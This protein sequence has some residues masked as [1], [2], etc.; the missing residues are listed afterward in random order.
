MKEFFKR[1][2]KVLRIS[3][4]I[5][6]IFAVGGAIF[7]FIAIGD[8]YGMISKTIY[9]MKANGTISYNATAANLDT[10]DL[11]LHNV[12]ANFIIIAGGLLF[13]VISVLV[14]IF[15][16]VSIGAPFG[17]DLNYFAVTILPHAIFEYAATII[18]LACAFNI[19]KLEIRMIKERSI[20][21]VLSESD[22]ELKDILIMIVLVAVLLAVAAVIECNLIEPIMKLYFGI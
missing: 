1:N 19:T 12:C 13:S 21:S 6:I 9:Q 4:V 11:F 18:A 14:T 17:T 8:N 7:G 5:F 2:K 22:R 15:N 20:K 3:L 16:A 10:F